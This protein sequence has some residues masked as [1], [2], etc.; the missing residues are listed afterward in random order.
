MLVHVVGFVGRGQDFGLVD[1]VHAQFLKY[2]RFGKMPDAALGHHRNGN[3][4][5]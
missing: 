1:V 4:A 5:P 3:R 2:L